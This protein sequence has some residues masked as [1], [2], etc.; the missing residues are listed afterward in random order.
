MRDQ[1]RPGDLALFYHSSC[2]Q[3][4]VAGVM[5]VASDAYPDPTQ[6]EKGGDYFD[7]KAT[8]EKPVWQLVDVAWECDF[9]KF[10][11]LEIMHADPALA[12]MVVL[13]R[14]N[15]LSITPVTEAEFKRVC[16]L[17]GAK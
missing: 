16:R 3:P 9:K 17:G 13:R 14:G 4:G 1:M 7:P 15:R 8:R 10:V 2:P 11:S 6:F 5:R 12:E